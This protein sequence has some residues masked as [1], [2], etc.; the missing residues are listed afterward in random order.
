MSQVLLA[1]TVGKRSRN[2]IG[3]AEGGSLRE[4]RGR[5]RGDAVRCCVVVEDETG[6]AAGLHG[7]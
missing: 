3:E 6:F 4:R 2:A 1:H 7:M 5:R